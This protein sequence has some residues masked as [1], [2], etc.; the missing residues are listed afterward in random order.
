MASGMYAA[1]AGGGGENVGGVA[2]TPSTPASFGGGREG[3]APMATTR[4]V[5]GAST[6]WLTCEAATRASRDGHGLSGQWSQ[7]QEV[8]DAMDAQ[9]T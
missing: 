2:V 4:A 7:Q 9:C 8:G 5:S 3:P 1:A 6:P